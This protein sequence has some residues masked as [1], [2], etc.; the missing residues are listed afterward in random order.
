M[1]AN[2]PMNRFDDINELNGAVQFLCSQAASFITAVVLS[3][4]GGFSS[5]CGV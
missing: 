1:L 5:F 3:V 4:D 2:T